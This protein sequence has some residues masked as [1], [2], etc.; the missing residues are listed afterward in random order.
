V[1]LAVI[2]TGVDLRT[3]SDTGVVSDPLVLPTGVTLRSDI[4]PR[5]VVFGRYVIWVN[6]PSRPI[7]I[8]STGTV[9]LL[10]PRAPRTAAVLTDVSGGGLT[11]TYGGVR[12]TNI[13]EDST[14]HLI[15]ESD[16][17]AASN[18]V[19]LA[20]DYLNAASLDISPDDISARRMYRPTNGGA[21]LFQWL[22]VDGNIVTSVQDDLADAG[23]SLVAA[24]ILGTPPDLTLI[25][26]FRDRLW[27]VGR[28]TVDDLNYSEVGLMYAWP[29]DNVFPIP[30]VGSDNLG[31][32]ALM[33]RRESLGVGRQNQLCMLTGEDDTNF[34]VARLSQN[35]G[36]ISQESVAIYRDIAYF[37][38]EDGVYQWGDDGIF[39]LSDGRVRS[40]FTTDD[41]FDRTHFQYAF[42]HVDPIRLKYRL[43]LEDPDGV[44]KWIE[45]DLVNKT[46]WG[47]HL[48]SAFTP[49]SVFT[50]L[51]GDLVPRPTVGGSNGNL[52]RE[53]ATRTDG[54]V[55]AIALD[56][57]TKRYAGDEPDLNKYW[58][59]TSIIGKV[60]DRG[61]MNVAVSVGELNATTTQTLQWDMTK[62][63]QR[64]ARAGTGKHLQMEFTNSEVGRDAELYGVEINPVHVLGRR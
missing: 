46:W 44:M 59:E 17:S 33:P 11:G 64:L 60:Q 51:D 47:P 36:V 10:C 52:Y 16:F 48:T 63:R 43:F 61:T 34:R 14:G 39:S 32:K 18:T 54:T 41:E 31:V 58:G 2:Q 21:V 8:D 37:L 56:V 1:S 5:S 42:G 19:S 38:W 25:A 57:I 15:S 7:T 4:P 26:E 30:S 55:T 24:P 13:I 28:L 45:Y 20:A 6:T 29:A 3:L 9:R 12:Y 35:L 49:T 40:W 27:G 22:D 23:L 50:L 62:N 53:Q